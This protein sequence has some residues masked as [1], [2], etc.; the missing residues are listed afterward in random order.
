[1]HLLYKTIFMTI[2]GCGLRIS[3][4]LSMTL[5]QVNLDAGFLRI[6]GKG[7]KERIVPVPELTRKTMRYYL[8]TLRP[9]FAYRSS[10]TFFINQKGKQVTSESVEKMLKY[11][12]REAGIDKEITP[13]KLR[14]S[15]ATHLLNHG[16]DLRAIQE[17]LGHSSI[18]TTEIYT[19]VQKERLIEGYR[20]YHAGSKENI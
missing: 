16:A 12:C 2:Y 6:A 15:Y 13:H 7:N 10:H 19:H 14:H 20:R 3:E 1:V 17:L 4:C 5:S 18:S 8:D 11:C 9:L